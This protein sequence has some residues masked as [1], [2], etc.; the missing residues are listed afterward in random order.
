MKA[1]VIG[2]S[3]AILGTGWYGGFCQAFDGEVERFALGGAP[4]VQL[5]RFFEKIEQKKYDYIIVD[6]NPNDETYSSKI[7]KYEFYI[8]LVELCMNFIAERG[9][10]ILLQIPTVKNFHQQNRIRAA[11]APLV[12]AKRGVVIDIAD[13]AQ[14]SVYPASNLWMRDNYH[15]KNNL[16]F[17]LGAAIGTVLSGRGPDGYGR[18]LEQSANPFKVVRGSTTCAHRSRINTRIMNAEF[19]VLTPGE[20]LEFQGDEGL[21][22]GM[23]VDSGLTNGIAT[24]VDQD[25]SVR[26]ISMFYRNNVNKNICLFMPIRDGINISKFICNNPFDLFEVGLHTVLNHY[27][28]WRIAITDLLFLDRAI[29]QSVV[30]GESDAELEAALIEA[31]SQAGCD[32]V[33]ENKDK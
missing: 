2:T 9:R 3:N 18:D 28:P 6:S 1:C 15:L 23:Y 29:P 7:G 12:R 31:C 16:A 11:I 25:G 21:C 17:T 30:S 14:R 4:L 22:L 27:A 10:I 20:Q 13:I 24:L 26:R 33:H 32:W 5:A 19:V 8:G